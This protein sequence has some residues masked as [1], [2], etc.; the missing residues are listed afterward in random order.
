[1]FVLFHN[2][3]ALDQKQ[4][5]L[6]VSVLVLAHLIVMKC[7]E[8]MPCHHTTAVTTDTC[9]KYGW[10]CLHRILHIDTLEFSNLSFASKAF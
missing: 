2:I 4:I 10:L 6:D 9:T 8:I 1:M 7:S 3:H 5:P